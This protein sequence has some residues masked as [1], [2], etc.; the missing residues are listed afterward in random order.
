M[1]FAKT[2]RNP[3]FQYGLEIALPIIGY[4]F[5][6]WTLPVIVA[7]YFFD[8]LGSEFA[9]HRRHHAV[10]KVNS[11]ASKNKLIGGIVVSILCFSIALLFTTFF[12]FRSNGGVEDSPLQEIVIFLKAEGWILLPIV[13]LAYHL[14]DKMTF[15]MSKRF[16]DYSFDRMVKNYLIE[17]SILFVLIITGLLSYS[18]LSEQNVNGIL[19]LAGFVIVKLAFD[20]LIV[21]RLDKNS[22]N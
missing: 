22:Q 17:I 9:R 8:Y 19:L 20:F 3:L 16:Y 14:K 2:L 4:L 5:L 18:Y 13:I 12:I 10:M 11:A 1:S 21:K 15:Y 6:G 7:F